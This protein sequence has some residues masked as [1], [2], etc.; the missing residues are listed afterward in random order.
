MYRRIQSLLVARNNVRRRYATTST[1]NGRSYHSK[2]SALPFRVDPESA[3]GLLTAYAMAAWQDVPDMDEVLGFMKKKGIFEDQ[4]RGIG[5]MIKQSLSTLPSMLEEFTWRVEKISPMYVP[6]WLVTSSVSVKFML[7][8]RGEVEQRVFGLIDA[9][10]PGHGFKPLSSLWL[11]EPWEHNS[12]PQ[13]YS[14]SML[15]TRWGEEVRAIPFTVSP[16]KMLEMCKDLPES[17]P[18]FR[19]LGITM[20]PDVNTD[21]LSLLPLLKPVYIGELRLPRTSQSATA[22]LPAW[23]ETEM[24]GK[25]KDFTGLEQ[26]RKSVYGPRSLNDPPATAEYYSENTDQN[27]NIGIT[28]SVMHETP[29]SPMQL[30]SLATKLIDVMKEAR[31]KRVD[32]SLIGGVDDAMWED[33]R[34]VSYNEADWNDRKVEVTRAQQRQTLRSIFR[35][36]RNHLSDEEVDR[37]VK[38]VSKFID[39][40]RN[41]GGALDRLD[42][43][44]V[45]RAAEEDE[46]KDRKAGK[47]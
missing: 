23:T 21:A 25:W 4:G 19:D 12:Q 32:W 27:S 16:L 8:E 42:L 7:R 43:E 35:E 22:I 39:K 2:V 26:V 33:S 11:S 44:A 5:N 9:T 41:G 47:L 29:N 18:E 37:K 15:T 24:G 14:P 46:E 13:S 1:D 17:A 40:L 20:M 31:L 45:E 38:I 34:I 36:E 6:T 28:F 10:I 30:N 3:K